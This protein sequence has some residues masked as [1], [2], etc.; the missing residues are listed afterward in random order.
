MKNWILAALLFCPMWAMAQGNP[1]P[2]EGQTPEEWA[3]VSYYNNSVKFRPLAVLFGDSITNGWPREDG[4]WFFE[5]FFVGRGISGQTTPQMLI[6]FRPHVIELGPE[7]VVILAGIN[8]IARNT[9]YIP[10]KQT[11]ANIAQMAD[12]ARRC[13]IKPILCTLTPADEIGWRKELGDPRPKIDSLNTMIKE[14]AAQENLPLADYHS[15]MVDENGGMI[16]AFRRDAVHPNKEGYKVMEKVLWDVFIQLGEGEAPAGEKIVLTPKEQPAPEIH[17]PKVYGARPNMP[18]I[19]RIPTSGLRPMTFSATGLPKG[20]KLDAQTGIITGKVR[21]AGEYRVKLQ[22]RNEAGTAEG[23]LTF[24]IGQTICLTPPMGW[25]SW[26][27]WGNTVSQES[28]LAAAKALVRTGLADYGWSYINID[29][30]WQGLRG[31][32]YG[33]IQPNSK[34]PDMKA[35]AD[36][37]HALGL[38]IGIYSGPWVCSYAGHIG[39]SADFEDGTYKFIKEGLHDEVYKVDRKKAKRGDYRYFGPYSFARADARQWADWGFDYLKYDWNPLDVPHVQEMSEALRDTP[40]DI[41]Y[42]LSNTAPFA[43]AKAWASLSNCFRTTDDIRDTWYSMKHIGFD[44][45]AFWSEAIGPGHWPDADMLVVGE[46]GWG[47][48]HHPTRLTPDE[49][50]THISLWSLLSSPLLIGCDLEKLDDFTLGL[51]KN[52]EIIAVNQDEAGQMAVLVCQNEQFRLYAKPLSDGSMAVGLFNMS[53]QALDLGFTPKIL[54]YIEDVQLRNMWTRSDI[55]KV[56]C[57]HFWHATIPPHGVA[58]V[59]VR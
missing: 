27:V 39:S 28:V 37:V 29:D 51:L 26:N 13:G 47:Q 10:L 17:G 5:R 34:F 2:P 6:R 30:G 19:F 48:H 18:V 54:G 4:G 15:A 44:G 46:L 11:L 23:E 14:Y 21:K 24:K 58:M 31:G 38:K 16:A 45:D 55:G 57:N 32:K 20:L 43:N 50:Y 35:L 42:S 22:A 49:Q 33:A 25:N 52:P 9:G 36:S 7:Y 3:K 59:K 41:V 40:R 8:D 56:D 53:Q 12:E 1:T